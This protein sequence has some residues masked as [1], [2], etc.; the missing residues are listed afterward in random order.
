MSVSVRTRLRS[1]CN[2][3]IEGA[4]RI[5]YG[6]RGEP[7][8]L[9]GHRLRY[10]VGTRPTR[11]KYL[12]SETETVSNDV[13]Q[14][15]Y[16]IEH[17]SPGDFVVDVGA[18]VGQYSVLLAALAG[19]AGKVLAFEPTGS[20]RDMVARNLALN[21]FTHRVTVEGMALFDSVG[22]HTFYFRGNDATASLERAGFGTQAE[23]TDIQ[24][25]EVKTTTLDEYLAADSLPAPD[26]VKLDAEGA[27]IRILHGASGLLRGGSR[28]LCELHPYAW[29][30]FGS[31]FEELLT[32]VSDAGRSIHYLD[33][34]IEI[35]DGP[36]Y[37]AVL[38]A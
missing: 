37:G 25:T 15:M 12:S 11:L 26:W 38:I 33:S 27:E 14:M 3:V 7:I 5:Y 17:V 21:G 35:A 20:A 29:P 8:T 28:V 2:K 1:S 18:N 30:A 34:R 13:R 24:Q 9:G 23:S 6:G 10:L 32:L 22:T 31:T 36:V 16:L 4:K 19:E